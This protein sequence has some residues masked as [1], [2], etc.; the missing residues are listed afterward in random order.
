M[1]G[2][3]AIE[4]CGLTKSFDAAVVLDGVDVSV[5]RGTVFALLGPNG[6]GKTTAVRI[7]ATLLAPDGGGARVAGYDVVAERGEVRRRIS[8]TGQYA[9]LDE[10][11]TGTENL[12]M[13][14]RL[15]HLPA[16]AA[17]VRVG[18]LL[19]Q[20]DLLG[21]ADRRVATYSGGMRRRLDIAA[22]LI[23][24]PEV[25]FL[26][27]PTT[28]LDLRSRQ[29]M[30]ELVAGLAAS[31]VTVLLTTQYLEEADCLADRIA[32]LDRGVI[33]AEGTAEELKRRVADQ[34]LDLRALDG[35]AFDCLIDRLGRRV[36]DRDRVTLSIG[37]A[38]GGGAGE[39]RALLDDLDPQ[40]ALIARFALN[41][42]SLDDV[43][44][45]LTGRDTTAAKS[46]GTNVND[47]H[48][49]NVTESE[50]IHV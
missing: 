28:G 47:S 35:D 4:A 6:A 15:L 5:A 25:I 31:G 19:A 16:R 3:L 20:F 50:A 8:L 34:R 43:F 7:L 11:L 12:E 22:S 49:T 29:A 13:M 26:D 2:E 9:A 21:A 17:R 46:H 48:D 1:T 23:G 45:A 42:A 32:V 39:V 30:W 24:R 37:V 33:V 10:P 41:T 36:V 14:A 38:S 18:E 40:R 27:E 44:M